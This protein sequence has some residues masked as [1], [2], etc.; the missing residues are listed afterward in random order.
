MCHLVRNPRAREAGYTFG[1]KTAVSIPDDIYKQAESLARRLN[2]SRSRLYA[3]ALRDYVAKRDPD[4]ITESWNRAVE[5]AGY[6]GIDEA[7]LAAGL[8][9]LRNVEWEESP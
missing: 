8:E 9:T 6:D 3:N 7:W 4:A 5:Q 2:L 1:M